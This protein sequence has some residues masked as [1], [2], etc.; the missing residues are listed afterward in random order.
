MTI[1]HPFDGA[2]TVRHLAALAK[3]T[4]HA[5]EMLLDDIERAHGRDYR[6]AL[7]REDI[8]RREALD[9]TTK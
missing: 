1:T 8:R 7:A 3:L 5:R 9:G 6:M 2:E 4:G